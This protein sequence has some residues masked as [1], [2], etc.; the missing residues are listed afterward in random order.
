MLPTFS[1]TRFIFGLVASIFSIPGNTPAPHQGIAANNRT[2][3]HDIDR[4][5]MNGPLPL[6]AFSRRSNWKAR[7][8]EPGSILG[9][10]K[11]SKVPLPRSVEY[12]GAESSAA[13]VTH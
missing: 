3:A 5:K 12:R 2:S 7:S 9:Y 4:P 10:R 1:R 8:P 6:I 13:G 11:S